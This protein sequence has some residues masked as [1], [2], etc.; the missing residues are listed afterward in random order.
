MK[1]CKS[2]FRQNAVVSKPGDGNSVCL[3]LD[4][5]DVNKKF[6]RAQK[7]KATVLMPPMKAF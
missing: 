5:K 3:N 6:D 2:S 1:K 7:V 4:S